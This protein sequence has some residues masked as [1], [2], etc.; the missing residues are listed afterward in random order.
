MAVQSFPPRE[1]C[2]S[3]YYAGNNQEGTIFPSAIHRAVELCARK[4]NKGKTDTFHALVMVGLQAIND[5]EQEMLQAKGY[6]TEE[7]DRER[8]FPARQ[9][10]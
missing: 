9:A 7:R 4:Y 3:S 6:E 1:G 2:E 5:A 10:Q 8:Q